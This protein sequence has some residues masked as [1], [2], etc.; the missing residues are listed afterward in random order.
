MDSPLENGQTGCPFVVLLCVGLF[1]GQVKFVGDFC[2]KQDVVQ[3]L[4]C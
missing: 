3:L 4:S 2:E 1:F